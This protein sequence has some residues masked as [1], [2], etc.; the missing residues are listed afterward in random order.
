MRFDRSDDFVFERAARAGELAV[1]GAFA[2][3]E[4]G[5][6]PED[7]SGKRRQA[8]R[9]GFLGCET[10]GWSTFVAIAV[11][12]ETD[13]DAMIDGLADHF[14][15]AYGA[16]D[17]AA[18]LPVARAEAEFAAGLCEHDANTLLA[19]E[20]SMGEDGIVEKFKVVTPPRQGIMAGKAWDAI[21]GGDDG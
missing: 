17:R 3:A 9:N 2:F 10:F 13:Y 5:A 6:D 8:F 11:I 18:A 16:P 7:W 15:A 21:E 19:V 1:S 20:R 14:V 4:D 12:T